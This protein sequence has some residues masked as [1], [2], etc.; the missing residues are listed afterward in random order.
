VRFFRQQAKLEPYAFG[1]AERLH[2]RV[3][4]IHRKPPSPGKTA[5]GRPFTGTSLIVADEMS[6]TPAITPVG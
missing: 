4:Y 1:V 2:M 6:P 5:A 3:R